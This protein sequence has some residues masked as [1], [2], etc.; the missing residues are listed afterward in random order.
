MD[1]KFSEEQRL[2]AD[3]VQRF[4][5]EHYSFEK[6]RAILDSREGWS[7]EIWRT[8]A[9]LGVTGVNIPEAH[10]GLGGGPVETM[11]VMNALGEALLLEPY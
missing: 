4:L 6:R 3:T 7:R 11:L 1:F 5:R 9:G 10:G 8:L 2:L